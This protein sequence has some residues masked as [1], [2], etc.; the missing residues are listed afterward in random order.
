MLMLAGRDY[1]S[2]VAVDMPRRNGE[3]LS[4]IPTDYADIA[5][6]L[7]IDLATERQDFAG[8]ERQIF[9]EIQRDR[10]GVMADKLIVITTKGLV[11]SETEMDFPLGYIVDELVYLSQ[12]YSER[13]R[14]SIQN[15]RVNNVKSRLV[16]VKKVLG[17]RTRPEAVALGIQRGFIPIQV[18]EDPDFKRLSWME[19]RVLSYSADGW[20][21]TQIG[22]YYDISPNTVDRYY[23]EIRAKLGVSNMPHA[24]RRAFEF[25][26]FKVGD[27]IRETNQ[28]DLEM[29]VTVPGA[30]NG[31]GSIS[32]KDHRQIEL[33]RT[34]VRQKTGWISSEEAMAAGFYEG[35][36]DTGRQFQFGRMMIAISSELETVAGRPMVGKK[37]V[38]IDGKRTNIYFL[39]DE[40]I[41]ETNGN[42]QA[43][44]P[45]P[46][47]L[48]AL[49]IAKRIR[50]GGQKPK[51]RQPKSKNKARGAVKGAA[52]KPIPISEPIAPPTPATAEV[53]LP[54]LA[55][56]PTQLEA[57]PPLDKSLLSALTPREPAEI[58]EN[59]AVKN[60]AE[61][62]GRLHLAPDYRTKLV[63]AL[64]YGI[65][66]KVVCLS[67]INRR[68]ETIK[69]QDLEEF[70][71]AYQ[72]VDLES[73]Y[74]ITGLT[75]MELLQAESRFVEAF[76]D[77]FPAL[78]ELNPKLREDLHR[79]SNDAISTKQK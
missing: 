66:P 43:I 39:R 46:E 12:G 45:Y 44:P 30:V 29:R 36:S 48:M 33:L 52:L 18:E 63:L 5:G 32:V 54:E 31:S 26:I 65:P 53:L 6:R 56:N 70:I 13:E 62:V 75:P 11:N 10:L 22:E 27:S 24:V 51:S 15:I 67:T 74:I 41:V 14:A 4:D 47:E 20:T 21:T 78:Q 7:V 68:G 59:V 42:V 57:L 73:A 2:Y 72:G 71:P 61:S 9:T 1:P 34:M 60:A 8:N 50:L 28:L 40:V 19:N 69:L 79:L 3:K 76:R 38:R 37:K 17:A 49:E 16:R 35:V 25:G 58:L 23:E 64:R 55:S 77:R